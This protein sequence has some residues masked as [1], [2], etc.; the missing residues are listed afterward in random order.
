MMN[1]SWI[2]I[3]AVAA[4]M[5]LP[6]LPVSS[7]EGDINLL[8]I[9]LGNGQTYWCEVE[10]GTYADLI[11]G[12]ADDLGLDV[13]ASNKSD[14]SINGLSSTT[15]SGLIT[16]HTNWKIY[17]WNGTNW[18]Y[19]PNA[20]TTSQYSGGI[21]A[22]GYYADD[23]A[24]N[25]ICPQSTPQ[26]KTVWTQF[27][28]SSSAY[29]T[30]DSY[31]VENPAL[32]VEWHRT[33]NTGY[34][35]SGLIVAGDLLYHTT[36]GSWGST[37]DTK[38]LWVYCLNRFTGNMV[39][40]YHGKYGAGYEVTTPV[41]V[42]NMLIL[43][44][45]CGDIYCFDRYNGTLL[46]TLYIDY[47]PPMDEDGTILWD[48]EIFVTGATTPVYD[49]G[50]LYF[51][52]ADGKVYCYSINYNE[53]FK[54]VWCYDPPDD[55]SD[56]AGYTGTKGTFYFH[57]PTIAE[58]DGKRMLFIGN[59]GGYL[60]ALDA[61]TGKAV[62]VKQVIDVSEINT[63]KP[64]L[65]GS[66]AV[67]SVNKES[68]KLLVTGTDGGMSVSLGYIM[69]LDP[70][71]GEG[72]NGEDYIWKINALFTTPVVDSDGFYTYLSPSNPGDSKITK[73]DGTEVDITESVCKFDWDGNLVW[74]CDYSKF[75]KSPLTLADGV[76][77]AMEY[78][79]GGIEGKYGEAGHLAA[80]NAEDGTLLW[81][82]F[83][84]PCTS[85]SYSM[86]QATVIDGKIYVGNDYGAVYCLSD[87]AGP[88]SV[89]SE[90]NSLQT[91]GFNHW[92]WYVLIA[93][94]AATMSLFIIFYR[95]A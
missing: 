7:A 53:G 57:A 40:E 12:A 21:A 5:L 29:N 79:A 70:K 83:L 14:L 24:E 61:A 1:K 95:G 39:W 67:V 2:V 87:I 19:N 74:M 65:P 45:T 58:V 50:A 52:S 13:D 76:L 38:D 22:V 31:G 17:S 34:V 36:G 92:S 75:V 23:S 18:E 10:S 41:V 25:V 47:K 26:Y 56:S 77:Y 28:G 59:Y 16:I 64:H 68:T 81:K 3:A 62:W 35:D 43:S 55:Y 63:A 94:I 73:S 4:L 42:G 15:V 46:H 11:A 78:S 88:S 66:A 30:S 60:H 89:E 54:E 80:V 8:L 71:T 44:S 93:A 51:G 82:V 91:A 9:D 6:A 33:Y 72:Y 85:D 37:T 48:A 84:E 32:P 20:T 90:I 69:A 49:S 86:V 27:G